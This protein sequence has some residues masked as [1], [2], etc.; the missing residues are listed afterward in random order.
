VAVDET[1]EQLEAQDIVAAFAVLAGQPII[2]T[3]S[4][5]KGA[6]KGTSVASITSRRLLN[7]DMKRRLP[8]ITGASHLSLKITLTK[9]LGAFVG[10]SVPIVGWVIWGYDVIR[11][12][13]NTIFKYNLLVKAED[14]LS[15]P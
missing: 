9:N 11:I 4:K 8:M 1:L 15:I 2:P 3:R 12:I 5:F 6:T 10:R 13:Q 7:Y 14:R